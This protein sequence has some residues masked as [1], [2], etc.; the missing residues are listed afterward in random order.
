[1]NEFDKK[2]TL[3]AG[4]K[5]GLGTWVTQAFLA[6]G[7]AV[8]GSSRSIQASD[9]DHPGF[10]PMPAELSSAEA[11]RS[12]ADAVVTRFGRIDVLVHVVG[13][14]AGGRP[15]ADTDDATLE[16]MLD[17][18]LRPVF[19]VVRA[20]IPHM[21]RQ[22]AGSIVVVGGRAAVQPQPMVGAY[23]ASKAAMLSLMQTLAMENAEAGI[24]VNVVL[25]GTMDTPANRA[26]DP[27]ADHTKWVP[28][29]KV[30]A[31]ILWLAGDGASHINGAA[32]PVYGRSL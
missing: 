24:N 32:V 2:V 17:R 7:A 9:F 31:A 10:T 3:I 16:Q 20:V 15:V 27:N 5:G 22:M 30:A 6:A 4:A 1:M 18:N 8:V 12:L 23:S 26:G 19:H 21:R 13:G 11:A 25:P 14:F 28:P 29:A